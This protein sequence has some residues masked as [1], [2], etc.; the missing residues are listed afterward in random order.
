MGTFGNSQSMHRLLRWWDIVL[1]QFWSI[2]VIGNIMQD[3]SAQDRVGAYEPC[4]RALRLKIP[5]TCWKLQHTHC[6]NL[7]TNHF[8]QQSECCVLLLIMILDCLLCSP[9]WPFSWG[10]YAQPR[11]LFL[12][13]ANVPNPWHRHVAPNRGAWAYGSYSTNRVLGVRWP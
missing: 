7:Y 8:W 13:C 5:R 11:G 3:V 6:S 9:E 10:I 1:I 2:V 12:A 4:A